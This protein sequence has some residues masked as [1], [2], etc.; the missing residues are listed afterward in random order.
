M[1]AFSKI[2]MNIF[3]GV[4]SVAVGAG[5][6]AAL[7]GPAM[8]RPRHNDPVVV[9][10]ADVSLAAS[11]WATLNQDDDLPFANIDVA[12]SGGAVVLTGSVRND[13]ERQRAIRDARM[14]P[15]VVAVKDNM[16]SF[17]SDN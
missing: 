12:A 5:T 13:S 15:G 14:V 2:R 10:G 17:E 8:A 7:A 11:V 16:T 4:F 9:T 6:L 3:A 1:R